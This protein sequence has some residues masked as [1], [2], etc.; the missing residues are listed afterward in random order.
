MK[1]GRGGA[2]KNVR[3]GVWGRSG[4]DIFPNDPMRRFA[5][6]MLIGVATDWKLGGPDIRAHAR[7]F[8]LSAEC[9]ALCDFVDVFTVETLRRLLDIES[10]C[11]IV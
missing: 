5:A 10:C 8:I 4:P 3:G 1:P 11:K 2:R 9:D 6:M 7:E